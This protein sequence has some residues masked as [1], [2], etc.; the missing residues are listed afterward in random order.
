MKI[1]VNYFFD[2]VVNLIYAKRKK[3]NSLLNLLE[4]KSVCV[5]KSIASIVIGHTAIWMIWP[6]L[7]CLML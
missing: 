4:F 6:I 2:E 7:S 5:E 3:K 1:I